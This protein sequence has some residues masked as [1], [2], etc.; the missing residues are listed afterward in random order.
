MRRPGATLAAALLLLGLA[1]APPAAAQEAFNV[2]WERALPPA[3][4]PSDVQPHP[5]PGCR[6]GSL[7]C[8]LRVERRLRRQWT[9]LDAACDHR[10]IA[11]LAYLRITEL[12]RADLSRERPRFFRDKRWMAFV[13]T[14]FSNSY[15]DAF[16]RY[17]RGL[18]VPEP[19]R[20]FYDAATRGET[21]AVQDLLLFSNAH[22]QHDLPFSYGSMGVRAP[23]GESHKPDHDG[24]NEVNVRVIPGV[25]Q[26]IEQRY[27]PSFRD[28]P[29]PVD[30]MAGLEPTKS[31]REG[32]W[33]NAE[34]LV[35]AGTAAERE[36]V[37][38]QIRANATAWGTMIAAPQRPGTRAERDAH[39]RAFR[40]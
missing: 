34:R 35:R 12:L 13:I 4:A 26:E 17:A 24:V 20:I 30:E 39:C 7:A 31:W 2:P 37:A 15:F 33:R 10:A 27:D 25:K 6:D 29:G 38:A 28:V 32:A 5:V 21:N 1:V 40:R 22:A 14:D 11:A 8:V 23:G 9:A 18:P 19:W 36:Q 16:D 3:P